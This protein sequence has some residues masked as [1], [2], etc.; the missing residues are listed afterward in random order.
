MSSAGTGTLPFLLS[1]RHSLLVFL[2]ITVPVSKSGR[3]GF[4]NSSTWVE[5]RLRL[6]CLLRTC[7]RQ[8]DLGR[9]SV[10]LTLALYF[11]LIYP[12]RS[13]SLPYR[14]VRLFVVYLIPERRDVF[15]KGFDNPCIRGKVAF[16]CAGYSVEVFTIFYAAF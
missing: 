3:D 11:P 14:V 13:R 15:R 1:F 7:W 12:L 9:L 5:E 10:G 16:S 2:L 6:L 4:L 8:Y